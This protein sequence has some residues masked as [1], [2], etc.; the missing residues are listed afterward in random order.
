MGEHKGSGLAIM[1]SLLAGALTGPIFGENVGRAFSPEE[2]GH[3]GHLFAALRIDNFCDPAEY[4][5]RVDKRIQS[6]KSCRPAK[7]IQEILFPGEKEAR[8]RKERLEKGIPIGSTLLE[9]L[10]DLGTT[11]GVK[12]PNSAQINF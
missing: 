12:F 5:Q 11:L 3:V 10:K 2:P 1:I 4:R 8:T 6:L 7:G 9:E